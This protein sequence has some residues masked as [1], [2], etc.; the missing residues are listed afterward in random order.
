MKVVIDTSVWISALL[1]RDGKSREIIRLALQEMIEPQM[2]EPLFLEYEAL[3][4]RE[5]IRDLC[6][7]EP[8]EIEELFEAYLSACQ[9]NEIFYHWRP[10][11]QDGDDDFLIELA[12]A[13]HAE[14]I[15]TGNKPDLL[16]GELRFDFAVLSPH[17][18]LERIA[19]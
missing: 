16:S 12:V 9:W 18:F 19:P 6:P 10:N 3:M 1:T 14:A 7:L 13:S 5:K 11:L 17:E 4:R 15:I 2:S 8:S